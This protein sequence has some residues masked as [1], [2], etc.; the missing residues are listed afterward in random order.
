MKIGPKLILIGGLLIVLPIAVIAV[1]SVSEAGDGMRQLE[2]EQLE[3]RTSEIAEG[4]DNVFHV[5]KKLVTEL[6][7]GNTTVMALSMV[8]MEGQEADREEQ[9]ALTNTLVTFQNT[10]GLGEDYQGVVAMNTTETVVAASD[11]KYVGVNIGERDY[12]QNAVK[13]KVNI[14]AP[15][16]NKVTGQLFVGIGAPVH[17]R[18]GRIVGVIATIVNLESIRNL[19][20]NATQQEKQG[21]RSSLIPRV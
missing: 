10:A 17:N 8:D 7:V 4:I 11:V 6:S 2:K 18:D 13:G 16:V 21:M 19:I 12:F 15:N 1:V 3:N 20:S 9:A 14:G 5:E